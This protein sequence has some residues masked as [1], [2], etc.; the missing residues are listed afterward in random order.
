MWTRSPWTKR[1][2]IATKFKPQINTDLFRSVYEIRVYLWLILILEA[3]LFGFYA[4][5]TFLTL[6]IALVHP[7]IKIYQ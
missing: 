6:L 2:R 5:L 4:G 1:S 3:D 7:Y